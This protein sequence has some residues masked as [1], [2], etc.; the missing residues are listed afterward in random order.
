[1]RPNLESTNKRLFNSHS[2][3]KSRRCYFRELIPRS[4]DPSSNCGLLWKQVETKPNPLSH[5]SAKTCDTFPF[6]PLWKQ[7]LTFLISNKLIP[8]SSYPPSNG[9]LSWKQVE[10]K[11]NPLSHSSAKTCDT[12][13]FQ[14]LW[15]QNLT[16]LIS[17]KLIPS[18]SYPPS[19]G[20]LLWK[21]VE[22]KPNPLSHSS[23]RHAKLPL[24]FP[25]L[26]LLETKSNPLNHQ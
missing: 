20:G 23:P 18:S 7:N 14:P 4:P 10:T 12:F 26:P 25:L 11:P 9:G 8:S 2:D 24:I 6:Q 1:M 3:H 13:P 17:N 16:F 22:T 21:Q 19:N 15:K 5:S